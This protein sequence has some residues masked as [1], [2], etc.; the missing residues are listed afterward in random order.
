MFV[1][2]ATPRTATLH[3]V[4]M[5]VRTSGPPHDGRLP[6]PRNL[7]MKMISD[8]R[9][10]YTTRQR[11]PNATYWHKN[12]FHRINIDGVINLQTSCFSFQLLPTQ[13]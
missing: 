1:F 11:R 5:A 9:D 3:C 2:P 6:F 13:R 4:L 8:G 7:S 10:L 12:E